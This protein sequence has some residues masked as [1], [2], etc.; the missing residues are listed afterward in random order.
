MKAYNKKNVQIAKTLR[1]NLTPQERKLW[2][3]FLRDFSPRFQ[4]QKPIGEYVVDFYCAKAQLAVELDGGG[5]YEEQQ[6][7]KDEKR[8]FDLSMMNIEV[9][10]FCNLDVDRNFMGVCLRIEEIVEERL[11]KEY[12]NFNQSK[13]D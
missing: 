8:T 10:R 12:N 13:D 11:G 1:K 7:K 4:R 2:Y 6:E 3:E 9:I 5:H